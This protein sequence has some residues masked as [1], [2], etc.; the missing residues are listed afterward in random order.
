MKWQLL[1][2]LIGLRRA[3]KEVIG[4][5]APG[6]GNTLLNYCGIRAD[7]LDYTVDRNPNKHGRF[8]PGTHIPIHS[9]GADRGDAPGRDPDPALEPAA[10]DRGAARVRP[11]L[12]RRALRPDSAPGDRGASSDGAS[13]RLKVVLF[14]GGLGLRM[15][16]ST[17][18]VPK[19][20]ITIGERPILWHI[21]KY[22][23]HLRAPRTSSSASATRAEVIKEFF[24][25][26]NEAL[27]ND[28]VLSDGGTPDR[29]GLAAT[30]T[31]G[32]S[33]SS[34]RACS[35]SIGQRLRLVEPYLGED[36]IFLANYG[37]TLT[38]APLPD[39]VE[40]LRASDA[41]ALFLS[42]AADLQLPRR[43]DWSDIEPRRSGIEDVTEAELWINAGYFVLRREI[44]DYMS[45][46]EELV[47]EPFRRLIEERKL[48]A[49]PYDGFWAPMD[50]LK[51]QAQP[52]RAATTAAARRGCAAPRGHR[53]ASTPPEPRADAVASAR[54]GLDRAA[55]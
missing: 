6:K 3:G 40:R 49:Y 32:R 10:G 48:L 33:P 16:E 53:A 34:T 44:F 35:R 15:G 8:L 52:R 51:E 1:E 28:F 19:P 4:Y 5:G 26:Y 9:P 36:E 27:T 7:L 24:L 20:M 23:A 17:T 42:V 37:D 21:M 2:L 38:D 54:H 29:A 14:C 13:P 30:S 39:M 18:R 11:G 55:R 12:G 45:A 50:T 47:E 43:V 41:T 46:G 31:T 25:D 22:Y